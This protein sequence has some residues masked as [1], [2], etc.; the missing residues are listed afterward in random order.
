MSDNWYKLVKEYGQHIGKDVID[1]D[2]D[3]WL[4]LALFMVM[5]IITMVLSV[6]AV[7]RN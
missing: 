4:F 6:E 7:M 3:I 5:M 1:S 2:G